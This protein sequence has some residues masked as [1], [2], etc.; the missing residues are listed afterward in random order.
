MRPLVWARL[1]SVLVRRILPV[2][3][4]QR[5]RRLGA[6]LPKCGRE[7]VNVDLAKTDFSRG[8]RSES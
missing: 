1:V 3:P 5:R 4:E 6:D 2:G 7:T 8:S